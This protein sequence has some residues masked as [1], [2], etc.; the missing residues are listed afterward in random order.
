MFLKK[1]DI[2]KNYVVEELL[3]AGNFG[4]VYRVHDIKEPNNLYALKK[5][6]S[7]VSDYLETAIQREIRIMKEVENYNSVKLYEAFDLDD[8]HFMLLELCDYDLK[9]YLKKKHKICNELEI[10]L[11]FS[12]LNNCF[13]KMRE[14]NEKV[15]HRDLKLDNI[16][17]KLDNNIPIL[18]F[19]VKLSDFGLSKSLSDNEITRTTVGTPITQA[20]EIIFGKG[21]NSKCDLWSIGVIIYQ[22]L[23]NTY[24]INAS[25]K[26]EL[27]NK[28]KN[29]KKVEV[30]NNINNPIS[31]E[32]LDLL[33]KLL[34]KDP[35][36]R[37]TFEEY[38]V[39]KFFSQE[40]KMKLL[41]LYCKDEYDKIIK[42]QEKKLEIKRI[43][44]SDKE[45]NEKFMKLRLIKDNEIYKLYKA[46]NQ[47]N[48]NIVYIKELLRSSIDK[49]KK[50]LNI[51][52]KEIK[53]LSILKDFNFPKCLE[54]Y[55][56]EKY[57]FFIFEYFNGN[58]LD[59]YIL[60]RKGIF[61]E[62]LKNSIILQ[63]KP[64]F[65]EMKKKKIKLENINSNNLIFSYYQNENNFMIKLFDY[66]ISSTFI[67]E[68]KPL[69]KFNF[70]D[71]I[72]KEKNKIDK[73]IQNANNYLENIKPHIKDEDLE[74]ILDIIKIKIEF[75]INYFNEL[76]TDK[77]IIEIELMSHFYKEIIILLYFCLL[78]CKIIISFLNIN[79]DKNLNE[80][81]KT[82]QEIHLLKI[83]L[84]NDKKYDYANI[85][86]LDDSKIWYYNKENP[87]FDYFIN[88]F[89]QMKNQLDLMLNKY[90]EKNKKCF[91]LDDNYILDFGNV[92][93]IVE[94]SI[95]EGN[96]EKLYSK[97]FENII[98]IEPTKNK[99]KMKKE[100]NIVKYILEYIIFTKLILQNDE[101]KSSLFEKIIENTKDTVSFS[102]FIGNKMK[103]YKE[104]EILEIAKTNEDEERENI[105]LEKLINFYIKIIKYIK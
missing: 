87:T 21:H 46:K 42:E 26:A 61:S 89:N 90:I 79:A 68:K 45:F 59:D 52:N 4:Q 43:N 91:Y 33:N 5:M 102:T 37:L 30:P 77:N 104:K 103:Y 56:T 55:E 22:L 64:T 93:S 38:F 41:K 28:I 80:I 92:K 15:I 49:N 71:F 1:D 51:F 39:H 74:N 24:P 12:Q 6:E 36:K 14:G 11:I 105:L 44:L 75:I 63:L 73:N 67:K 65:S 50:I 3:G 18:G 34:K 54:I 35:E 95:K 48:N 69:I 32:C 25:S 62:S 13:R 60:K 29:F 96:L 81:D 82:S 99:N 88:I 83:Y 97:L 86:F 72:D 58:I 85:N 2:I 100:L 101:N 7:N 8:F 19:I 57:Y 84:N 31:K 17:I 78:E 70:D 20:P 9:T 10:Y 27:I 98:T 47:E 76:F 66:Y 40:H 53:L 16:M 23:F 94:K